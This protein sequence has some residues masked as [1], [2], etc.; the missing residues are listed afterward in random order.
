M[1]GNSRELGLIESNP[2]NAYLSI[3]GIDFP[4][5]QAADSARHTD[6]I[7]AEKKGALPIDD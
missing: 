6:I 1:P 7:I 5:R 3:Y 2:Q 4:K